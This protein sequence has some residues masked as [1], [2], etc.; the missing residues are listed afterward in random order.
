MAT[1]SL[2]SL[3]LVACPFY[4]NEGIQQIIAYGV[5]TPGSSD[6]PVVQHNRL[7]EIRVQFNEGDT[8]TPFPTAPALPMSTFL[9]DL[10]RANIRRSCGDPQVE[11]SKGEEGEIRLDILDRLGS[12][13]EPLVVPQN[14][15]QNRVSNCRLHL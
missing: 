8:V 5:N 7:K 11:V 15:D 6:C 10:L 9:E 2:S 13:V 1:V 3:R 14:E 12:L 4:P